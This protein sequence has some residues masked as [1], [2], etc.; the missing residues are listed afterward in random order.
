MTEDGALRTFGRTGPED[1]IGTLHRLAGISVPWRAGPYFAT[2]DQDPVLLG[3]YAAATGHRVGREECAAWARLGGDNGF[4]LAA[5]AEGTVWAVL[6]LFD[7]AL[8]GKLD[9]AP[10]QRP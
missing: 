9:H 5:D 10:H 7:A 6:L 4:E 2:D 1:S 3:E 8:D